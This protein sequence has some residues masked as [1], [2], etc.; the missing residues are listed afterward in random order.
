MANTVIQLK[1]STLT[2]N[3]PSTLANGEISINNR[4]GKFFYSTPAGAIITHYPY[5]GPA[6]LNQEIQ[7]NDSGSLGS[8]SGLT[9]SKTNSVL[10]VNGAVIVAGVNVAPRIQLA[11]NHANAAFLQANTPDYVANSAAIYANG[12]FSKANNA[13]PN[14]TGTFSG[15]LSVT[16]TF[17]SLQSIGDEGGQID[18]ATSATNQSLSGGFVSIDIF[19]NKLRIFESGG[20]NRGAYIDLANGTTAGV[21]TNLLQPSSSTDGWARN[22]A[23]AAFNQA[24]TPSHVANSAAIYANGAFAAANAASN[25]ATSAGNYANGAFLQANTPSHV[26]NSAA[27]Y[28]N[29]AFAAANAATATDATQNNSITAAFNT[30]NAAFIQANTPSHV[31]NSAAI[32]ANGAFAAANASA[33]IDVTQNNSITAA[34]IRANNSLNANVGGTVTGNVVVIGNVVATV[35][36][37]TGSNGTIS[38]A[39]AIFSN[40]I[41]AANGNVDLYVYSSRAYNHANAAFN[42]ANTGGGGA[43]QFARNQANAAFIQANTPSHVA[44]SAAI[45][46]NGAFAAANASAA[47]DVTQNNNITVALNTGNAAFIQAN[48]AFI[49]ANTPSHVANSAAIYANGAFAAANASAAIDV[50]QNNNITVALNTG[51]AAFIQANAAF[52]KANNNANV[53]IKTLSTLADG[54]SSTYALGFIPTSNTGVIV[55]I[56]GVVQTEIVD[57]I[58]TT[59]NSTI[60]FTDPPPANER[61]RVAGFGIVTPYFLDV[62]NSAGA[63][64]VSFNGVGD[65][66]TQGYNIGF[67]PDSGNTIFVSIGG[68]LQPEDAFTVNPATNT[69]TFITAPQSGE[70]IRVVGYNK[71]NPYYIQYVS[72]NVSVSTFE[73]TANGNYTTFNLGFLPQAREVLIVSIDGVIQ[74]I[75]SYTVD[76]IQQTIT[77]DVA[78]GNNELVRVITMYTTANAFITPDASITTTKL[79][80]GVTGNINGSFTK[81]NLAFNQANAAF[82]TANSATTGKAIA[83]SI[84]FG[85]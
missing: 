28:A 16:E 83:M 57:Y 65:G 55:S 36:S 26:A 68:I 51:N 75:T 45:Y 82:I 64:V 61:I 76:N 66:V 41:F 22:Q 56:G 35:L 29:G 17:R 40:Y 84:V 42:Q 49:Q 46:A 85:G 11:Y 80:A 39:N 30:G 19:Q 79:D 12:A 7:F 21:G 9:Y 54:T 78:P 73:T 23:N 5:T 74:P 53:E 48:A 10:T 43:D 24:N 71:V 50:T 69:V 34:F 58:I 6:G 1:H 32:Y 72:S 81:A 31:A 44:N 27:I 13:L 77:F 59:S 52:N 38:S 47:I 37:T 2:G 33:A 15:T 3:V 67:R 8:N 14:A 60:S 70:N 4:D 20:T 62:A 25:S 18:L 63:V